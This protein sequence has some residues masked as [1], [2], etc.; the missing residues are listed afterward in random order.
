[1][2]KSCTL[3][4]AKDGHDVP[5]LRLEQ[6]VNQEI[7]QQEIVLGSL[8][9]G[10][11]AANRWCECY[12]GEK[13]ENVIM[14]GMGDGQILLELLER[15]PGCVIVYEPI[16]S[17]YQEM[18]HSKLMKKIQK[19]GRIFIFSGLASC[20]EL[21]KKIHFMLD[22]DYVD[23]TLVL[24]HPRYL[25]FAMEEKDRL[26]TL[27]N[28]SCDSIGNMRAPL[29]RFIH[30][31]IQNQIANIKRMQ[32]GI[33]VE[34][35]KP[36][37]NVEIPVFIVSAG[38]SLQKNIQHLQKAKE[39]GYIFAVDTAAAELVKHGIVPDLIGCLDAS[40]KTSP[41]ENIDVPLF[42]TTNTPSR[43]L[44]A[45]QNYKIW[46]Y[47]HG[48]AQKLC[49]KCN[50]K[51]PEMVAA[52]GVATALMALLIEMGCKNIIFVGQD[53]SYSEDGRSH[54]T[55]LA[56]A[57]VEDEQY[58]VE[59]YYGGKV[60]SRM[61]WYRFLEWFEKIIREYPD[62]NYINA[63]E[64]GVR[65]SGTT[66][67]TLSQVI[68]ELP[69][70]KERL[71]EFLSGEEMKISLSEFGCIW[72]HFVKGKEDLERLSKLTYEDIFF[73]LDY[74]EIPVM[75][76]VLEV[77]KTLDD[78]SRMVRFEKALNY[79]KGKYSEELKQYEL[80]IEA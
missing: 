1:M 3:K 27:C 76:L 68:E 56:E 62:R 14:L 39:K 72:N 57:Y 80:G 15:I 60:Q 52:I 74:K 34:R 79:V 46:G 19:S 21:S 63:T 17:I 75:H 55:A 30:D 51:P 33:P 32:D 10:R 12:V 78:D 26:L 20:V 59:G 48:F 69:I 65:I 11:H 25:E 50:I 37:W 8:Y 49:E 6:Q 73:K 36:H 23:S 24:F 66:Q 64:G 28:T 22:D 45:N 38:P 47:D 71:S 54:G 77:M 67:M 58:R 44:E 13:A 70:R 35:M 29:K 43:L 61:D 42:V 16:E 5:V 31:M 9:D 53:L 40:K 41:F 2:K 18:L 7:I 4:K